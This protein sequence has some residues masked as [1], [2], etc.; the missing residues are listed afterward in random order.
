L[1]SRLTGSNADISMAPASDIEATLR[2]EIAQL[3]E[4][5]SA[6]RC[7]LQQKLLI[8]KDELLVFENEA[9]SAPKDENMAVKNTAQTKQC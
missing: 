2:E 6:E 3:K 7:E 8:A 4:Q 1:I 5:M 9:L